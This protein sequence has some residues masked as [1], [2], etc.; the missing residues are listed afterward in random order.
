MLTVDEITAEVEHRRASTITFDESDEENETTP[1]NVA[2]ATVDPG[3]VPTSGFDEEEEF[4]EDD[5]SSADDEE[6]EES[7]EEEDEDDDADD[8]DE[9]H[10]KAFMSTGC[11]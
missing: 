1:V 7:E 6:D 10:G 9:D 4:S 3:N 2:P 11:A 5:E 8:D